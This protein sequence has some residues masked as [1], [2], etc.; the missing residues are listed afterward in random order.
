MEESVSKKTKIV[1]STGKVKVSVFVD[2]R[3]IIFIDFQNGKKTMEE[4]YAN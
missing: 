4:Y 2:A 3:G 1:S